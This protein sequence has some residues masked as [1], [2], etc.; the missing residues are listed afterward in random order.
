MPSSPA[1]TPLASTKTRAA[2]ANSR[3]S[4]SFLFCPGSFR[5]TNSS[6]LT[7][8]LRSIVKCMVPVGCYGIAVRFKKMTRVTS[9]KGVIEPLW[10]EAISAVPVEKC[11][12]L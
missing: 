9:F 7:K 2:Q 4:L 3:T 6:I 12:D 11:A 8:R 1:V 5:R 10:C